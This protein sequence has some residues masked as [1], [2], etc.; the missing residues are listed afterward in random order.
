[1]KVIDLGKIFSNFTTCKIVEHGNEDV[2]K[3]YA[4]SI[5][6]VYLDRDVELVIPIVNPENNK[7]GM[8]AILLNEDV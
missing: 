7:I 6:E 8:A 1:M 4:M 2:W 5:P 3:G